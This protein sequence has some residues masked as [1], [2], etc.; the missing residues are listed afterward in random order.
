M[1]RGME[2]KRSHAV[3]VERRPAA[4]NSAIAI[5]AVDLR[6]CGDKKMDNHSLVDD[7]KRVV[8]TGSNPLHNL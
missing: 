5:A 7:D 1:C 6:R 3:E 4:N 8:P 2:A